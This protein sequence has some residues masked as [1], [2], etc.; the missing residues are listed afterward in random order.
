MTRSDT[1]LFSWRKFKRLIFIRIE[2]VYMNAVSIIF[3]HSAPLG[4]YG[5][6]GQLFYLL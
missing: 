6:S 3:F 4:N 2:T 5:A 1:S